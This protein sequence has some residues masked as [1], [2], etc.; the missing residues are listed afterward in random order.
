MFG[1]KYKLLKEGCPSGLGDYT[2]AEFLL[3]TSGILVE[4]DSPLC[5]G[6]A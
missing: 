4:W 6:Q 5:R 1:A 2:A 3:Y